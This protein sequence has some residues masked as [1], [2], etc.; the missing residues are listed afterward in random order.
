MRRTVNIAELKTHLSEVLDSVEQNQKPLV[1]TKRGRPTVV[2]LAAPE[3]SEDLDDL[4]LSCDPSFRDMLI[5][6]LR[7]GPRLTRKQLEAELDQDRPPKP[8][9]RSR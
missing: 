4:L 7:S 9:R 6:S 1:V 3:D 5:R 2:I 8:R